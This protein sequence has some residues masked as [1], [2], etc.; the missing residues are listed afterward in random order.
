LGATVEATGLVLRVRLEGSAEQ[1]SATI[2]RTARQTG[3]QVRGLAV[4]QRSLEGV[5][6]EAVRA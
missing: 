5:F 3:A 2:F 4:A 6:E 1:V